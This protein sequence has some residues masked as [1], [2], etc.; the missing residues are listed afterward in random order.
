VDEFDILNA[1]RKGITS[2]ILSA[3]GLDATKEFSHVSLE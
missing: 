2:R 3:L 1:N